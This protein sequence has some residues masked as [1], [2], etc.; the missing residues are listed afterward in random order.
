M[1]GAAATG[2]SR[3]G[4]PAKR[5][6][7]DR[8]NCSAIHRWSSPRTLTPKSSAPTT[9]S[10]ALAVLLTQTRM[11]GGDSDT[12]VKP[13]A[14]NPIGPVERRAATMVTPLAKW[15]RASRN[16]APGIESLVAGDASLG[17]ESL[18]ARDPSGP[19][20]VVQLPGSSARDHPA[21]LGDGSDVA[22]APGQLVEVLHRHEPGGDRIP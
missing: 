14:V 7:P 1:S 21:R 2:P 4:T 11:S 20:I 15:A 6:T 13:V 17:I 16:A 5:S 3:T 22:L 19:E 9:P 8:A 10:Y 12:E 18:M